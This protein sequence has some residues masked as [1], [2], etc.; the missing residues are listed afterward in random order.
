[1]PQLFGHQYTKHQLLELVGDMTQLAG[2]RRAVLVEGNERGSDLIEVLTL[3]DSVF[4]FCR[5]VPL[6]S[7]PLTIRGCHCAFGATPAMWDPPSTSP[8]V[9]GGCAAFLAGW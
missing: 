7:P 6:I 5:V 8:K 9:M 4:R 2:A 3:L 1:M